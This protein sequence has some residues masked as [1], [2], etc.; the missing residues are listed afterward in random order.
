MLIKILFTMAVIIVV[1]VFFRRKRGD[2]P[3]VAVPA[4]SRDGEEDRSVSPRTLAYSLLGALAGISL[5]VFELNRRA[6]NRIVDIRVIS[7]GATTRYRAQRKSIKGRRFVTLD[8]AQVIL[9]ESDRMELLD[10]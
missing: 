5:L 9:G 1:I 7:D 4:A 3:A 6:Q 10:P 2:A 8:G